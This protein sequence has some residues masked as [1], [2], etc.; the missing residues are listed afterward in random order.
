[1]PV[2][3]LSDFDI[4]AGFWAG[5]GFLSLRQCIDCN[6]GRHGLGLQGIEMKLPKSI[7]HVGSLFLSVILLVHPAVGEDRLEMKGG[8]VLLG[9]IESVDN[10]RLL[11]R[12]DY[13]G[14]LQVDLFGIEH[15]YPMDD[16]K[17]EL[18]ERLLR[19]AESKLIASEEEPGED[20]PIEAAEPAAVVA[21]ESGL[22]DFSLEMG[23]NF[24]GQQGNAD[25]F[26]LRLR[27][28]AAWESTYDRINLYGRYAYG[29]R[30]GITASDE[31]IGGG[32]YTNFLL[33]KTGI[34][35]RQEVEFDEFEG[36]RVRSTS[37]A[38]MSHQ[39]INEDKLFLETRAGL[40]YR[41]EDY[42]DD[43]ADDFPGID[44]G[45]DIRWNFIEW[46]RFRG[47]YTFLPSIRNDEDFILEQD[48]SID[49]PLG[50][51][52]FW[53]MRMGV[54]SQYNNQPDAGRERLDTRM[55]AELIASWD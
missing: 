54:S 22:R 13:A 5:A 17:W 43:G 11:L 36:I 46:A 16:T 15:L 32:R 3:G 35:V 38:G 49:M 4:K 6:F 20:P 53:K 31:I 51:K 48:S 9:I 18:P 24:S 12:T 10:E 21:G 40:S 2:Q 14:V 23:L 37:A 33:D 55:Y 1:M 26:D 44:L 42:T 19:D 7:L 28:E 45:L 52:D 8:A 34:F 39:F 47:S 25:R 41:Y 29:T 27:A 30:R 50:Q